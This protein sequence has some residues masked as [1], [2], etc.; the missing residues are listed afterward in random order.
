MCTFDRTVLVCNAAIV[1]GCLHPGVPEKRPGAFGHVLGGFLAE[2]LEC[3]RQAIG[4]VIAGCTAQG[5]ERGLQPGGQ[6]REDLA[7]E[8]HL[9]MP[10]P[11]PRKLEVI[12]HGVQWVARQ[13]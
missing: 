8:N 6:G 3:R 1:A 9:R 2:V 5:P 7:A 12:Q 11:R 10:E 4:A 13:G